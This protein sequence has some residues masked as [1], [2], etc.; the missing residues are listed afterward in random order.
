[1]A[2]IS[3]FKT[4]VPNVDSGRVSRDNHTQIL[5]LFHLYLSSPSDSRQAIVGKILQRLA[6]HWELRELLFQEILRLGPQERTL[7]EKIKLMILEF[8]QSKK[9]DGSQASDEFFEVSARSS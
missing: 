3:P 1:M 6:S 5:A 7:V 2:Q 4:S 8:Q 9:T